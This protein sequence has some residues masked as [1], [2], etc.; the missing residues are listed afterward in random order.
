MAN[1]YILV[2][3]GAGFIGS[4]VNKMLHREGYQTLVLD[5]LSRGD[6]RT[7]CYG[8]FIEGDL[9][10]IN[11]LHRIFSTYSIAAVM[12]FAAYIDV[13]NSVSDPIKY[14]TNNV[15]CTLNLLSVM[16]QY[17]VKRFIFSST[18]AIFGYPLTTKMTEDHP[19]QPI[20][21]YG[22][23][24][25]MVEKILADYEVAYGLRFC[26]LRYF[27]AA[28]G[29]PEGEIKNY[30]LN[31]S[32]L[33]P[34]ILL[35]AKGQMDHIKIFG[36]DYPTPDGTCVRDYIHIEDLGRAHISAMKRLLEG[37][38]SNFYNLGSGQG[39]SVKEILQA[40][41]L[42]VGKN[43]PFTIDNRRMGDPPFLLADSNKAFVELQWT[44]SFSLEQMI[45]HAWNAYQHLECPSVY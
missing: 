26:C 3:G 1:Q 33:I 10:D 44:P 14:Y 38:P 9:A 23:T 34:R 30:Q 11:L 15:V 32:N 31:V 12:H 7:V 39:F 6:K 4:H 16:I 24:K 40:I 21:P 8:T 27:N 36:S 25:W 28:G 5:N 18:A 45:H 22:K 29:D 35:C 17:Q 20:N 42:C 13:G 37:C 2:V 41:E 19:C 43:L